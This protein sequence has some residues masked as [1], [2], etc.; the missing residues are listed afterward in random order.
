MLGESIEKMVV[1]EVYLRILIFINYV[2][3]DKYIYVEICE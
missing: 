1:G 3:D 2:I